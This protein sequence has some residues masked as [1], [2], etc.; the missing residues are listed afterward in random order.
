MFGKVIE[1]SLASAAAAIGQLIGSASTGAAT[2]EATTT[3]AT[4]RV[5]AEAA[6]AAEALQGFTE[7][8]TAMSASFDAGMAAFGEPEEKPKGRGR[9]STKKRR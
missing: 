5:E 2:I 7:R 3:S 8:V 4:E 1:Q 9:K 6:K